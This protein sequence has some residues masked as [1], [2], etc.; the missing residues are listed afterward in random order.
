MYKVLLVDDEAII[1]RGLQNIINWQELGLEISATASNGKEAIDILENKDINIL[2]TDIRMPELNGLQLIKHIRDRNLPIH[3]IVLSGYSE[4][5]YVK[6]AAKLGIENYILKPIDKN[7][8]ISTL[9]NTIN[10]IEAAIS[11]TI[12]DNEGIEIIRNNI[13]TRWVIGDIHADDLNE[14][15]SILDIDIYQKEYQVAIIKLIDCT[16]LLS[17]ETAVIHEQIKQLL[18]SINEDRI[19]MTL[20]NH[21]SNFTLLFSGD[22]LKDKTF[23]IDNLLNSVIS[24]INSAAKKD[25][26][27]AVGSIEKGY[28]E[29]SKSYSSAHKLLNYS[30]IYKKNTLIHISELANT[31]TIWKR[32]LEIDYKVLN[33][34]IKNKN[35]E[36][37]QDFIKDIFSKLK[38]LEPVSTLNIQNITIDILLYIINTIRTLNYN[39][40]KI[41]N[42]YMDM[43]SLVYQFHSIEAMENWMND[44]VAKCMDILNTEDEKISPFIKRIIHYMYQNYFKEINLSTVSL[45]YHINS[46]YLGQQFKKETGETFNNYLNKIRIEQA[47]YLM[48]STNMKAFEIALKVGYSNTNYFSTIFKKVTGYSPSEFREETK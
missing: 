8:L 3:C 32:K 27:I 22:L 33:N 11:K 47:K 29:V 17:S 45:E 48:F 16:A 37:V 44:T 7:E 39:T 4:F 5:G 23:E 14:R 43:L 19:K 46:F 41:F 34:A 30:L 25:A 21:N 31:D 9:L 20:I 12:I 42:D 1:L 18:N 38:R 35:S 10:K 2:I 40:D 6:E 24:I 28:H 36:V 26:F 15:S 13:L